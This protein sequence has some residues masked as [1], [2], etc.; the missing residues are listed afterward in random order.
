MTDNRYDSNNSRNRN[1]GDEAIDVDL[2]GSSADPPGENR[3]KCAENTK[4]AEK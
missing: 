4:N 1:A 3:A 2:A